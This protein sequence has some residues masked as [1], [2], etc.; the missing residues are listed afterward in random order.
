M[1]YI[2]QL[3]Q[4]I[5]HRPVLMVG[6]AIFVV[7]ERDRLLM[8]KR[9]DSGLWGIPGGATEPGEVVAEAAKRE[10]L[11]EAN[12]EIV[13]MSLFGVFSGPEFYYK[14]PN[15]DEVY[16]VTVMYL[17]RDWRGEIKLN[18]EH[19]EWRWFS[20][21]EIPEDSSPPIKP[22]LEQY[23]ISFSEPRTSKDS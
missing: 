21:D 8:L 22:I 14:Y 18:D 23:R 5:G 7:D 16:N 10:T 1:D 2:L 17:S 11:E 3:R 4:F 15:G 6:A 20:A 13:E 9:S 12:L 19:T